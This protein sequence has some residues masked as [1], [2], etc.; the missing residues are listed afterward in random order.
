[1][2][3]DPSVEAKYPAPVNIAKAEIKN[4]EIPVLDNYEE[5]ASD[6][7]WRKFPKRALPKKAAT[8]V[9]ILELRKMVFKAGNKMSR[10]EMKRA[11]KVI[12]DLRVGAEAYQRDV[13]PPFP[14]AIPRVL[15][16]T[17][18]SSQTQ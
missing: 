15:L 12:K 9:N 6:L 5:G 16:S 14:R 2:W 11:K 8:K 13:L 7:F 1:M 3:L 18:H 10:C 17:V 4:P